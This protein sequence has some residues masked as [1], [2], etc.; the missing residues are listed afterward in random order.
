MAQWYVKD[1]SKLTKVSVQTLHH[2]DKIGLLKPSVRLPN[3]YRLYSERDLLR[4]QQ[5]IALKFFGFE[6]S[7]I[8]ILLQ[9]D[10]G[11]IDHFS[12]QTKLLKEKAQLFLEA[13]QTLDGIISEYSLS[14]SISWENIIHLIE[15]Y[16]MTQELSK[17][18]AG[19]ALSPEELKEY[20]RF[21]QDVKTRSTAEVAA[22]EKGWADLVKD[23]K[24]N[25]EAEPASE[26]GIK[27]GKRCM[28]LVNNFYG[29][30]FASVKKTVWEKGYKE[31]TVDKEDALSPE[32]VA[33]LDKAID[34]YYRNRIYRILNQV[35]TVSSHQ[36]LSEWNALLEE[37]YGDEEKEKMA[38]VE[39]ALKEDKISK[40]AKQW[41][42]E[43]FKS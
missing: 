19:K 17:T 29:K 31:Q 36:V 33:W 39:A 37:M 8:K 14:Q 12:A 24:S 34:T 28:D 21:K 25:L 10:I 30:E 16:R 1:L 32:A 38:L 7:Q 9:Q 23:I 3:G 2:Y 11:V 40:A 15:V 41:L 13:S 22:F 26:L 5:I 35:G 42:T 20:A 6:L 27:L 18:W 4:L 43:I